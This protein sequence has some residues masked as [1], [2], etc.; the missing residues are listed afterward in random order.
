[1]P[2]LS[3]TDE[4][5]AAK[6]RVASYFVALVASVIGWDRSAGFPCPYIPDA[7]EGDKRSRSRFRLT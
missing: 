5:W 3:F 7:P 4:E 1:V 2:R 6:D